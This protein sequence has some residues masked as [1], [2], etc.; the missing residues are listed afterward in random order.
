MKDWLSRCNQTKEKNWLHSFHIT[1]LMCSLVL[2][3][4]ISSQLV[5][6]YSVPSIFAS[7]YFTLVL[8]LL[9]SMQVVQKP[10][11]GNF[12][13][14]QGSG[15]SRFC[16]SEKDR[17]FLKIPKWK[18]KH[19]RDYKRGNLVSYFLN[20]AAK[21]YLYRLKILES[22]DTE[23]V[24]PSKAFCLSAFKLSHFFSNN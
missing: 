4:T 2:L 23:H 5:A 20:N 8:S 10:C 7:L 19:V 24:F 15:E 13:R 9:R 3:L 16:V 22:I 18:H 21:T 1:R 12:W 6:S 11:Q 14:F 17:Y